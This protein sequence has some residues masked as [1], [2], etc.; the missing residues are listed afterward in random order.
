[1]LAGLIRKV[2]GL[3]GGSDV[4]AIDGGLSQNAYFAQFLADC[5]GEAIV[6]TASAELTALGCALL[7]SAGNGTPLAP[8]P[9]ARQEFAPRD[10]PREAWRH[11]LDTAIL[12]ARGP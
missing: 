11:R 1:M 7:A 6:S 12:K 5:S 8:P 3:A 2:R 4:I 9:H 10:V